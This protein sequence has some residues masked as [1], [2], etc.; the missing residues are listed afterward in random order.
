[1]KVS[2]MCVTS[3]TDQLQLA[4]VSSVR[5]LPEQVAA[6]G[7]SLLIGSQNTLKP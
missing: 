3:A 4:D 7:R 6:P 5:K 2:K 1:M